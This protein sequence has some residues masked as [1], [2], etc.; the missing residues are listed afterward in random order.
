M[1]NYQR[2]ATDRQRQEYNS[3]KLKEE[4]RI[5]IHKTANGNGIKPILLET[6]S[7]WSEN[8]FIKQTNRLSTK[9]KNTKHIHFLVYFLLDR[10][11]M[12]MNNLRRHHWIFH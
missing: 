11:P 3:V 5:R 6:M 2:K 9:Y 4:L 10:K 8:A 12:I 7:E 1:K